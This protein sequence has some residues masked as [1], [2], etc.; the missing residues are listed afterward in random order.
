M[1]Q[2]FDD[3]LEFWRYLVQRFLTDRGAHSA[4]ALTYTT[5]FAVVPMMT[6]TFAMLS[7]IPA[8]QGMSEEIQG[9]IFRNFVPST[10]VTVQEYLRAFTAQARQ[11]TWI[12]V[13]FLMV[14]ALMM[15]L[16]IEK[17]FNTI[18]RVRQPRR[19]VSSFL[20]Y[21]AILSLGPLLLGAGFAVSTYV[22]S[23]SLL[24]GPDALVGAKTALS[25]MPLVFSVAAFTLLYAA[26]PNARVPVRH[27]LLGGLFTAVL[28]EAAKGLFSLYVS[29]FPGYQL[30][31][32]AF[33][34][35]PLFLL[36][37]YL[38]WLIVLF[39]AELVCNLSSSRQWRRRALP[40]LLVVLGI[41]RVFLQRQQ[42]G[43]PVRHADVQRE[44]WPLPEDEW[45]EIID[46]LE[47]EKLVCRTS[48]GAWVLCRDLTHYSMAQLLRHSPWPLPRPEQ[49]QAH[50]NEDWYQ[51][52]KEALQRLHEV[53]GELFGT[54]LSE[55]LHAPGE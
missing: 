31:Y 41:L 18:W 52:L 1:R 20:L 44:G 28:F 47:R 43:H 6:V 54:S 48:A 46:F 17:A 19:G 12:G 27:A 30:I 21:W 50:L 16:T 39:G 24:S 3:F 55:W 34:T 35:V 26:V 14:T 11:L 42:R 33:A 7:A 22:T 8:F 5:L 40:R 15:L 29:L 37:I 25:F 23:L 4:A 45:E 2:R 13:G 49:L 38:S 10:G 53:Q 36:W 9:F 32:G 51:P